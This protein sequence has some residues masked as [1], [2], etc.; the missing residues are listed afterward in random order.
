MKEKGFTSQHSH[1]SLESD[2]E[3]TT[4]FAYGLV[5]SRVLE[6]ASCVARWQLRGAPFRVRG[7]RSHDRAPASDSL[8]ERLAA[9]YI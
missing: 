5:P 3:N 9:K 8:A 1:L 4:A 7:A 2:R 6:R